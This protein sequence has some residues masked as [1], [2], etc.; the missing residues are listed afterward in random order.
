MNERCSSKKSIPRFLAVRMNG[1]SAV[2]ASNIFTH[3][4]LDFITA[5]KY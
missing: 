1:R 4:N 3:L 5:E 2:K